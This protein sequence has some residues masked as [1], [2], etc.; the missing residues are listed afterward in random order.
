[1]NEILNFC[2]SEVKSMGRTKKG[3]ANANRN[4]NAKKQ[5]KQNHQEEFASY[6]EIESQKMSRDMKK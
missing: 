3:N 6:A 5:G 4:N 2:E 1:M